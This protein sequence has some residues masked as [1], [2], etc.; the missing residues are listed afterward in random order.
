MNPRTRMFIP[1]CS[2]PE[3]SGLAATSRPQYPPAAPADLPRR[4]D[5]AR[6]EDAVLVDPPRA[7]REPG[8]HQQLE[9][10]DADVDPD[11][12]LGDERAPARDGRRRRPTAPPP[13]T[14]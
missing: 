13:A 5:R 8:A 10:V 6:D 2:G 1:R 7:G 14:G 11:Q 9:Q 3:W 4:V 12:R